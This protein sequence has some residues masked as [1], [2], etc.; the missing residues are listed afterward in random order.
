MGLV[1]DLAQQLPLALLDGRLIERLVANLLNNALKFTPE[2]G[3]VRV[4]TRQHG[5]RI[6]VEVWDSGPGISPALQPMLFEKFA[7]HKDSPG[8]G[9][10]L[11]I[12]K[13]IVDL[14]RGNISVHENSDGVSFVVALPVAASRGEVRSRVQAGDPEPFAWGQM[15]LNTVGSR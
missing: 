10:G 6:V 8:V 1:L 3:A 13:S 9:L 15:G 12:C 2:D 4:S 11:Y 14:H 7:R 5:T